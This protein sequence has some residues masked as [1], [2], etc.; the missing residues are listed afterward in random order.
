MKFPSDELNWIETGGLVGKKR[1]FPTYIVKKEGNKYK[2]YDERN[3][4]KF[5]AASNSLEGLAKLLKPYIE[6]RTGSWKFEEDDP[7]WDGYKQL[8]MKEKDGKKVPNCVPEETELDEAWW[9]D[10][11][12]KISQ[13]S[14]PKAWGKVIQDYVDGMG[15]TG[16]EVKHHQDHP[17]AWAA[18]VVKK[19]KVTGLDARRLIKYINMLVDKGKLPKQLKAEFTPM[20]ETMSFKDFVDHINNK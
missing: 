20:E 9:D 7:C 1:R 4:G 8:G 3:L 5:K 16:K 11:A 17:S 6:K 2:A 14:H 19:Y 12:A 13:I 15:G 18:D 10:V